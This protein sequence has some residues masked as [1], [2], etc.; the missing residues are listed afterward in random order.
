MEVKTGVSLQC[1]YKDRYSLAHKKTVYRIV[2]G[3][4]LDLVSIGSRKAK[5]TSKA[6][7]N[8]TFLIKK[9]EFFNLIF[10]KKS[11]KSLIGIN[12]AYKKNQRNL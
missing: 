2:S 9:F 4:R 8:F 10:V 5:M 12:S 7:K 11:L 3:P 1:F 6:K